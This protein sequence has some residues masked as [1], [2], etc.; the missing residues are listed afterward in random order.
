MKFK[1][2]DE[3]L[4]SHAFF[5]GLAQ[6][7]LELISGCATNV[8]FAPDEYLC[9]EEKEA[10]R[11]YV[12]RDGRVALQL[13][14]PGRGPLTVQT[15]EADDIV[16]YSWLIPPY[17]WAF[18]AVA[19]ERVRAVAL[20]GKCLRGKCEEDHSLGYELMKRVSHVFLMR[21]QATRLQL[22]DIYGKHP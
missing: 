15:L 18:D 5:A 21:L 2:L 7:W 3:I 17:K 1:S 19:L 20:D 9:R 4:H 10:D 14:V 12:I 8:S 13:F 16:G 6:P 11:F 22:A